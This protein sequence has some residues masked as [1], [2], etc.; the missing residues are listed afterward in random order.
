M[1]RFTWP[2]CA[3]ALLAVT[4]SAP[5]AFAADANASPEQIA[6]ACVAFSQ[7]TANHSIAHNHVDA[8]RTVFKVKA[9]LKAGK[10]GA[11]RQAAANGIERI[12][13]RSDNHVE[14]IKQRCE[15]TVDVLLELG[16]RGLAKRVRAACA[17]DVARIRD[18]Q[19]RTITRIKDAFDANAE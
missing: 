4:V 16:A 14:R 1:K 10:P 17:E 5:A 15:L 3:L 11:A 8:D 18:S 9:L 7:R 12:T 6:R 13:R 2:S 19:K